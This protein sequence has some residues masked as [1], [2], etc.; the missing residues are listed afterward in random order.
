MSNSN[1]T[2]QSNTV[3][4]RP[5]GKP[6]LFILHVLSV[7]SGY[8]QDG[9]AVE[10]PRPNLTTASIVGGFCVE[11]FTEETPEQCPSGLFLSFVGVPPA[12][13]VKALCHAPSFRCAIGQG[14]TVCIRP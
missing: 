13:I 11:N 7:Y 5:Q 12:A 8:I 4:K 1:L 10:H 6:L 3:G 14:N 9:R 2:G